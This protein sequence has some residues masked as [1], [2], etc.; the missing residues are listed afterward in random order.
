MAGEK[1]I[2]VIGAWQPVAPAD[3][4]LKDIDSA[5]SVIPLEYFPGDQDP[6]Q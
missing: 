5:G 2:K 4:E 3:S 1:R 6:S